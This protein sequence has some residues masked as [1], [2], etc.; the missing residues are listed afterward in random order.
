MGKRENLIEGN[1]RWLERWGIYF[2][3][4]EVEYFNETYENETGN[5]LNTTR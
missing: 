4:R 1:L 2:G 3:L 5:W